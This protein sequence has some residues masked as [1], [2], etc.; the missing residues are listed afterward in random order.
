MNCT[1]KPLVFFLTFFLLGY[2]PYV[3]SA[4]PKTPSPKEMRQMEARLVGMVNKERSQHGLI[5]LSVWNVLSPYAS[6]H[7]Q[8]MAAGKVGFGHTGFEE[9][10]KAIRQHAPLQAFGENVAYC[11]LVKDPLKVAVEKWMMSPAHRSNILDDFDKTAIA[12]VCDEKGGFY[13]TQLFAK[14]LLK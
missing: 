10:A 4:Q 8:K 14:R 2:T 12:I 5:A 6:G 13:I 7:S 9:R 1:L 11:Q 3:A